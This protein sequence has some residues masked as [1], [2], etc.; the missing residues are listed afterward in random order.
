METLKGVF[1]ELARGPE[2]PTDPGRALRY[3]RIE[4]ADAD[5]LE[6]LTGHLFGG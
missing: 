2:S 5:E 3:L 1:E 4:V 6:A